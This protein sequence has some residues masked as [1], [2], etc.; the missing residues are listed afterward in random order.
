MFKHARNLVTKHIRQAKQTKQKQNYK[1]KLIEKL[2][3]P[4][5]SPK[6]W[7]KTAK[8][9][10]NKTQSQTIPTLYDQNH[11]A[12]TDNEKVDLLNNYFSSQS[13]VDD[14][15][16]SPP[17]INRLT[18]SSLKSITITPQ[19][20]QDALSLLDP[21]KASGPDMVSPRLL[22][23]GIHELSIP[24]STFSISSCSICFS[25]IRGSLLTL[26]P[27]SKNPILLNPPTTALFPYLVASV[28]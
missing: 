22:K 20:V 21:S 13:T 17:P 4:N 25:Q 11:E 18:E 2:N 24:L 9:L 14:R 1:N 7:F 5:T 26:R 6:I 3:Q 16:H 10:T 12:T 8:Q 23:E 27:S 19:D 15:D 28:N